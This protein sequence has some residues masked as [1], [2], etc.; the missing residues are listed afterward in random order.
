[1]WSWLKPILSALFNA[2]FS[3]G[4]KQAEKPPTMQDANTPKNTK[5]GWDGF[6]DSWLRD[7]DSNGR[8]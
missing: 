7:Q 6:L 4:Q 8:K 3:W 1:M 5:R 2:L